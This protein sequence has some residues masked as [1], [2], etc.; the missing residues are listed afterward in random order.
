M[1]SGK[2]SST[3][4][5]TSEFIAASID[6]WFLPKSE[7]YQLQHFASLGQTD[8]EARIRCT[9]AQRHGLQTVLAA[10]QPVC[11]TMVHIYSQH[12]G[13]SHYQGSLDEL[14][15]WRRKANPIIKESCPISITADERIC[16]DPKTRCWECPT[17]M[18]LP[19]EMKLAAIHP[20]V[21]YGAVHSACMKLSNK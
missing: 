16:G 12:Y 9:F 20:Q 14:R 10:P 13:V 2:S 8:N 6:V 18:Q 19:D 1:G 4:T 3:A 21:C 11:A 17:G 15:Y 7:V 5:V